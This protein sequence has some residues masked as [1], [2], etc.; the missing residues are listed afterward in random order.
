MENI[1]LDSSGDLV[2]IVNAQSI[3]QFDMDRSIVLVWSIV[4]YRHI[5]CPEN[6]FLFA[7]YP[8]ELLTCFG[9]LSFPDDVVQRLD[10]HLNAGLDDETGYYHSDIGL[11][12][13]APDEEDHCRNQNRG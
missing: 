12:G 7:D 5:V 6:R 9:I 13:D 4:E 8:L 3:R 1:Q 11:K 2:H 10:H